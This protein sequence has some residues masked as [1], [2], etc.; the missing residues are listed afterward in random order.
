MYGAHL[1][2]NGA[3]PIVISLIERGW[4]THLA[5]NGAGTIHDWNCHSSVGPRKAFA[6]RCNGH[7][8]NLDET[9]ASSSGVA[10]GGSERGRL[11]QEPPVDSSLRTGS[12]CQGLDELEKAIRD[13]PAHRLRRPAPNCFRPMLVHK[14]PTG[15]IEVKHPW[16]DTCLWRKLFVI[17]FRSR[18]I[19][20]RIRHHFNH[21][22]SCAAIGRA[23]NWISF[24]R[25]CR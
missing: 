12:L 10:G 19:R 2:K 7:I 17:I 9:D 16:A 13:E 3:M 14:L 23:R 24:V 5:T 20:N 8:R 25:E 6:E 1:I 21:P 4:I 22:S 18:F 15:R 11:R